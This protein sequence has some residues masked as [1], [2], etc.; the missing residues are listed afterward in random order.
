MTSV[1]TG[2]GGITLTL[3]PEDDATPAT[4]EVGDYNATWDCAFG[5]G[6]VSGYAGDQ[7]L[8]QAQ[9]K[10]LSLHEQKVEDCFE[11]ARGHLPQYN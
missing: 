8:T 4:V 5:M 3:D 10:W 6:I 7:P 11:A 9:L 2:P 1:Y